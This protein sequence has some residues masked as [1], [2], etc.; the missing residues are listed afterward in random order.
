MD[1]SHAVRDHDREYVKSVLETFGFRPDVIPEADH[2]TPDLSVPLCAGRVLVEVKSKDDDQQLRRVVDS[3]AGTTHWY[4][5][6][7]TETVLRNGWHQIRDFPARAADDY[8][9]VWLLA[10]K[11]RITALVRPTVM[12]LLYGAQ[13][14]EGYMAG[15]RTFYEKNCFFFHRS[16]FFRYNQLDAV[17][18]Q[19][20]R[21]TTLC[22]NPLCT[23][24]NEFIQTDFVGVFRTRFVIVDPL[25]M[26][27]AGSCFVAD[28]D[29][30]R[31]DVNNVVGYLKRK[32][33]LL[34][35]KIYRFYLV[36]CPVGNG[37]G[38]AIDNGDSH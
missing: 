17:V 23:R 1:A 20:N 31:T 36:N 5:D 7:S 32:Y 35:V 30:P 2:R 33:N 6:S 9:V 8:T 3:P 27:A 25:E 38:A 15:T 12:T 22:I 4:T 10:C 28:C 11:S 24:Y 26:E 21:D 37:R 16:L 14:I 13:D 19:D 29:C 18:L 34:T